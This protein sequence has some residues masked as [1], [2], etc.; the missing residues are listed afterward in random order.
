MTAFCFQAR[1]FMAKMESLVSAIAFLFSATI[2]LAMARQQEG[3]TTAPA[4]DNSELDRTEVES[5]EEG[6]DEG[7]GGGFLYLVR[8]EGYEASND[9]WEPEENVESAPTAI[10]KFWKGNPR[11]MHKYTCYRG[12]KATNKQNRSRC[13][14][15]QGGKVCC[16]SRWEGKCRKRKRDTDD[17]VEEL[18]PMTKYLKQLNWEG[19][20]EKVSDV[21]HGSG[22]GNKTL[23]VHLELAQMLA[24]YESKIRFAEVDE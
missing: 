3:Q 24:F 12:W 17:E 20:V 21:R 19:L 5:Q 1:I 4:V 11:L 23:V 13:Y 10:T 14:S 2:I 18:Q 16:S 22:K 9:T 15:D 8:W 6:E 7:Y